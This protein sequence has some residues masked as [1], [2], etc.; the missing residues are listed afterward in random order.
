MQIFFLKLKLEKWSRISV[1]LLSDDSVTFI[2]LKLILFFSSFWYALTLIFPIT[3]ISQI[4]SRIGIFDK[5]S[6]SCFVRVFKDCKNNMIIK[7]EIIDTGCQLKN[8][9]LSR[10]RWGKKWG[11]T[12]STKFVKLLTVTL[13]LWSRQLSLN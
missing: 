5:A 13:T 11:K 8:S 7:I 6:Q 1:S 3:L 4:S 12:Y 9:I 2:C 10:C